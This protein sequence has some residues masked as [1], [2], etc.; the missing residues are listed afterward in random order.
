MDL[1]EESEVFVYGDD[2]HGDEED[3]DDVM[4]AMLDIRYGEPVMLRI[5]NKCDELEKYDGWGIPECSPHLHNFHTAPE[6]DGGPWNWIKP[7]E[8]KDHHYTGMRAGFS[9]PGKIPAEFRDEWGGDVRESLTTLFMHDHRPHFTS[10]NVYKGMLLG[11]R[12]FDNYEDTGDETTGWRLPSG[13][14]DVPLVIGDKRFNADGELFY[15]PFSHDGFLGDKLTV[16]GKIQPYFVVKPRKYRFRMINKGVSRSYRLSFVT[17]AGAGQPFAVLTSNGNFLQA[18]LLNQTKWDLWPAERSDIVL[19]FAALARAGITRVYLANTA[20]M[21]ENGRGLD[22]GK[23]TAATSVAN[24]LME[25]RIEGPAVSDPSQ[26]P[27][28]FR[29]FPLINTAESVKNRT[30]KFG[31]AT[32]GEWQINGKTW[33]PEVD[34]LDAIVNNPQNAVKKGTAEIWTFD[35]SSGG[36]DHPVH[37]HHEEGLIINQS[38]T[39]TRND[40]YRMGDNGSSTLKFLLRFRDFPHRDWGGDP[41]AG[42]Y[43]MHCHN[44]PHEDH[45]MMAT[46]NI[47]P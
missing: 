27:T 46:W 12:V 6:S 45:S 19:D 23:T 16:N 25:F 47:R 34:H 7:G 33:D 4:G 9:D 20:V 15:E 10:A 36:W 3:H 40:V 29:P 18:P 24:Q 31:R 38:G 5:R 43:V 32:T 1:K 42:R 21:R 14:F 26:I 35:S 30:F 2:C 13:E 44:L 22:T 28:K 37:V 39:K 8:S 11:A 41:T 17:K